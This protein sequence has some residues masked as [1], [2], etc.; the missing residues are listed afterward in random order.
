MTPLFV[1]TSGW[2]ALMNR[3]D[4]LHA[5]ATAVYQERFAAGRHFVTHTGVR[6]EVG[7]GLSLVRLR[8][9]AIKLKSRLEAS[10]RIDVI[11]ITDDL[12]ERGW[13]MYAARPDKDWGIIDCISFVIMQDYGLIEALTADHHFEQAGFIRLL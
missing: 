6:L 10:A 5:A 7:N 8:H 3:S 4:A 2:I 9:L 13:E 1:D 12:Y 11:H